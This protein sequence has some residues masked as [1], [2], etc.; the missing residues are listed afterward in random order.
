LAAYALAVNDLEEARHFLAE[1]L[2]LS[3]ESMGRCM[4]TALEH[5]A[6]FAALSGDYEN[7]A[8]LLG[9]TEAH[10]RAGEL[11]QKTE[12][13]GY[14]RL[15]SLLAQRYDREEMARRM[16]AG[17]QWTEQQALESAAAISHPA[18][19]VAAA[20]AAREAVQTI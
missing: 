12:Q 20:T 19:V 3:P 17:A 9:F 10:S 6:L 11:R 5:H 18:T 16:E 2:R 1:T 8:S 15:I 4:I 14:D 7:A 13:R